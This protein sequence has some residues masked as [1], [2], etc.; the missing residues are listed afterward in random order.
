MTPL[1]AGAMSLIG[2]CLKPVA[3]LRIPA[4]GTATIMPIGGIR[5]DPLAT[6]QSCVRCEEGAIHH[7]RRGMCGKDT[8][9]KPERPSTRLG[10]GEALPRPPVHPLPAGGPSRPLQLLDSSLRAQ[11]RPARRSLSGAYAGQAEGPCPSGL[12]RQGECPSPLAIPGA[13]VRPPSPGLRRTGRM[14]PSTRLRV[15]SRHRPVRAGRRRAQPPSSG[16][17]R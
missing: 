6:S 9:G 13:T 1:P 15:C 8:R 12:P 7:Y 17:T 3:A 5:N 4:A 2:E 10:R 11:R 16:V 14:R